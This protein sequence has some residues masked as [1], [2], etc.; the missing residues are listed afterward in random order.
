MI[1]L[2]LFTGVFFIWF[3]QANHVSHAAFLGLVPLFSGIID[4]A[5]CLARVR[6]NHNHLDTPLKK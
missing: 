1:T 3:G 6:S 4:L 2:K 5:C